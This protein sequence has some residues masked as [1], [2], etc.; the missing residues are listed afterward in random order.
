[1]ATV[2]ISVGH[3]NFVEADAVVSILKPDKSQAKA[4]REAAEKAGRLINATSGRQARSVIVL[5]DE[6]VVL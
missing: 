3:K 4:S 2:I 5:K 1:M 6:H